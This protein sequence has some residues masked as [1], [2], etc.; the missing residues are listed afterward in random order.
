MQEKLMDGSLSNDV[1]L[2]PFLSLIP[3]KTYL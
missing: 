2:S 1:S 3:V